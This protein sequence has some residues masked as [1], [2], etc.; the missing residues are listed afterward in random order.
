MDYDFAFFCFPA[1]RLAENNSSER[2]RNSATTSAAPLMQ[3]WTISALLLPATG[4]CGLTFLLKD[5]FLRPPDR[6]FRSCFNYG[7][8]P[9]RIKH[10]SFGE[11]TSG[12]PRT[13]GSSSK[14]NEADAQVDISMEKSEENGELRL[15]SRWCGRVRLFGT[16]CST[17]RQKSS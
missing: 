11:Q 10:S 4:D 2:G 7:V 8:K 12:V 17:R 6:K 5:H 16:G 9:R 1:Q 3:L 15:L 14:G 13:V